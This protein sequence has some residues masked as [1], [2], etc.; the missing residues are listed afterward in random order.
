MTTEPRWVIIRHA[1]LPGWT[2]FIDDAKTHIYEA[3]DAFQAVKVP[4]G[5]HELD[6]K[7]SYTDAV[8]SLFE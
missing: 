3:D 8:R 5:T 2:A 7:F 1:Y 6:L 4:A